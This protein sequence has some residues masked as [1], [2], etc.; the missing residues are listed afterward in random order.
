[1]LYKGCHPPGSFLNVMIR[2][3]RLHNERMDSEL[4]RL[5]SPLSKMPISCNG[6][7]CSACSVGL[8]IQSYIPNGRQLLV[9]PV[10]M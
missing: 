9:I 7:F 10:C 5:D 1:M 4:G 3:K 2:Y 6:N 8:C